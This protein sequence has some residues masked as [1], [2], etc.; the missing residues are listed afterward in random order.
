MKKRS[1][2][3]RRIKIHRSYTVESIASLFS[4]HKNTV[5]MW[6]KDGLQTTDNKRPM[7]IQGRDLVAFLQAR[8]VKNK[9]KCNPG[10]MYCV[11]C[12]APKVPAGDMVDYQPINEKVGNLI[13][14]CSCCY[15]GMNRRVSLAKLDHALGKMIITLPPV[16]RHIDDRSQPTI[17]SDLEKAIKYAKT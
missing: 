7:L 6:I 13:A 9:K 2:N 1:H 4:I 14:I 17:N 15:S 5:R 12:H 3:Y 8:R 11:R 16:L 10:E